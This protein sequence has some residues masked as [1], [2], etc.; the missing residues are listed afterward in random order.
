MIAKGVNYSV[1]DTDHHVSIYTTSSS[2]TATLP[3]LTS[4]TEMRTYEFT[5]ET[6]G[7]NAATIQAYGT[8]K[9][10][11]GNASSITLTDQW[12]SVVLRGAIDY[13]GGSPY[14]E[15]IGFAPTG[16]AIGAITGN[17]ADKN[18]PADADLFPLADSGAS[19][20]L[21]HLTWAELKAAL[22]AY[23]DTLY[24]AK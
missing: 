9:I 3:Q 13:S 21:K 7:A 10:Q 11:P 19:N 4:V 24:A 23:F 12:Q 1:T 8:Q 20:I 5:R 14:W 15:I 22:K 17:A 16:T 2:V 18:T 6:G